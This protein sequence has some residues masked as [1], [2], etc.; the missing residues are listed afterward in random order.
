[1]RTSHGSKKKKLS[2]A[3]RKRLRKQKKK[4]LLPNGLTEDRELEAPTATNHALGLMS[5][6]RAAVAQKDHC[7]LAG[8]QDTSGCPETG[9]AY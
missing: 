5:I 6:P 8:W 4:Q 1:M 3:Q 2:G 9:E 7:H